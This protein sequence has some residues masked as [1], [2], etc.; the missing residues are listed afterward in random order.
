MM[1]PNRILV[2]FHPLNITRELVFQFPCRAATFEASQR[3]VRSVILESL[4]DKDVAQETYFKVGTEQ[5]PMTTLETTFLPIAEATITNDT[6]SEDYQVMFCWNEKMVRYF[7][8]D[9]ILEL[10]CLDSIPSE[11]WTPLLRLCLS[12]HVHHYYDL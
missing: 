6:R 11:E 8:E 7:I 9:H 12:L 2:L 1:V 4:M 10:V 3:L 5:L